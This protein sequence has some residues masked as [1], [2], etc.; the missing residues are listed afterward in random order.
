MPVLV[1]IPAR[2]GSTRLPRKLLQ[3][4]G[5]V[6]L[7]VRV[8]ERAHTF[9]VADR[10]VVATDSP[11]ILRMVEDAGYQAALTSP[12]HQ[13]GTDRVGELAAR[14]EFLG[15]DPIVNVQGDA[16]FLPREAAVGAL[17]QLARGFSIGTAAVPLQP[18]QRDDPACVKVV[19][20]AR[21][22][23][24][25]FSR[26]P[27]SGEVNWTHLGVYAFTRPALDRMTRSE[28]SRVELAHGLEQL[29]AMELGIPIGVARLS[30][31]AGPAVDTEADLEEARAHW[32]LLHEATR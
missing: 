32:T 18:R 17:D 1:V 25:V 7:V 23:A 10:V 11:E 27:V 26:L 24:R 29:R 4:V 16:P 6:P 31:P 5:G 2:L 30:G 12:H 28:P 20:D 14:P 8:A 3:P 13:S 15:F 19:T 22:E 21:G 9:G